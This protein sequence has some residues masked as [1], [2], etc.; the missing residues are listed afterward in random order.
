MRTSQKN[1]LLEKGWLEE[2]IRSAEKSLDQFNRSEVQF[3]RMVF[4]SA[5]ILV[6]FT[7]LALSLILVPYLIVL[8]NGLLYL[9]IVL[10]AGSIG[11]LYNLLIND[12]A[13]IEKKHHLIAGIILPLLAI[14]NFLITVFIANNIIQELQVKNPVHNAWLVGLVFGLAFILP[15]LGN[16]I[17]FM[18]KERKVVYLA[19][20]A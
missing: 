16:R 20:E 1:K 3:S 14:S 12:I 15:Y 19:K 17:K 9:I 11:F 7:N 18:V 8:T 13:H 5:L 4:W 2:E 10:L 6:I